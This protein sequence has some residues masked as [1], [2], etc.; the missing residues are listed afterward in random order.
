MLRPF[1]QQDR[2]A[3]QQFVQPQRYCRR[4]RA[5]PIAI[6]V[7]EALPVPGP[8]VLMQEREGGADERRL[9]APALPESGREGGLAGA[10]RALQGDE[11]AAASDGLR[12][13]RG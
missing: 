7:V 8:A 13:P 4:W 12:Q 5:Q 3:G 11:R 1:H 2:V 9:A 6:E 10:E